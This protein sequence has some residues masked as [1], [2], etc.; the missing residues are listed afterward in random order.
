M[1]LSI[2]IGIAVVAAVATSGTL[3]ASAQAGGSSGTT[4]ADAGTTVGMRQ[5]SLS[6]DGTY[7][8]VPVT[9]GDIT[10]PFVLDT[11]AGGTVVS[12]AIQ[13]RLGLTNTADANVIG[14]GGAATYK[15]VTLP[16][17]SVAGVERKGWGA[18][19]I[20]LGQ[21][22]KAEG[23]PY[24]GILGNNLLREFDVEISIPDKH[25]RLHQPLAKGS[26]PEGFKN[27]A[28]LRNKAEQKGFISLDILLEGRPVTAILDT[29]AR[30]SV[31]NWKAA[32]QAGVTLQ[33]QGLHLQERPTSGLGSKAAVTHRYTFKNFSAGAMRLNLGEVRIA[34]LEVFKALGLSDK[35]AM[36]L[37]LDALQDR[38]VFVSYSD[39]RVLFAQPR[40]APAS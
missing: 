20:D 11:A 8:L 38:A 39:A 32:D 33:T 31:V 26:I 10:A 34:D 5:A 16:T 14:A 23:E 6:F 22:K 18:L 19:V 4:R 1:K 13:A 37:G 2:S 3:L 28:V 12:P 25:L 30:T 17:F 7:L 27:A 15:Q 21:F 9:L 40:P 36:I 35:P 29:G 24:G